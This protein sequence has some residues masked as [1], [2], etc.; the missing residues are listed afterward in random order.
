MSAFFYRNWL[1]FYILLFLFIGW[2]VYSLLWFP[3]CD[4]Y[5][6]SINRLEQQLE[7]CR[8]E[9]IHA[10]IVQCN[11]EVQSGGF[12]YTETRHEL[13]SSG[14]LVIIQYDMN[15]IPDKL[16]VI[17]NGQIVATTGGLVSGGG[18]LSFNY[19]PSRGGPTFCTVV[20]SAPD[21]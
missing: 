10:P 3:G 18:R 20:V 14:G 12:G 13:G 1:L 9:E 15:N 21:E 6:N 8:N 4:R 19:D 16:E 7:E 5:Q 11:Q 17:Y 2:F